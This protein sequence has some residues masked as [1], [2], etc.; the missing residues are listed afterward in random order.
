MAAYFAA[1]CDAVPTD[2]VLRLT[3]RPPRPVEALLDEHPT[4]TEV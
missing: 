1:S 2:H 4:T 3:G